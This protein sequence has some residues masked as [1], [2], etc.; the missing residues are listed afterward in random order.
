MSRP[1]KCSSSNNMPLVQNLVLSALTY[2]ILTLFG[3]RTAGTSVPGVRKEAFQVRLVQGVTWASDTVRFDPRLPGYHLRGAIGTIELSRELETTSDRFVLEIT[4]SPGLQPNL[5]S[6]SFAWGDTLMKVAP[7]SGTQLSDVMAKDTE[8]R[9]RTLSQR[10]TKEY[11]G[12]ERSDL[13]V[14]VTLLPAALRLMRRECTISWID[15]YRR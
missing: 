1:E 7:F 12:F 15:W 2:S 5:E 14:I 6:F 3:C 11:F 10:E 4:T 9:W 8:G 13:T